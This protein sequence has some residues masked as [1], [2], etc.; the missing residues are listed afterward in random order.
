MALVGG[1]NILLDPRMFM[2]FC[3]AH[4]L[5]RAGR[6]AAFDAGAD[7]FVR[8]EG[9][10]VVLLKRLDDAL[11]DGDRIYAVIKST[12]IN[13]DGGTDSIT[14]PNPAAQKAMLQEAAAKAGIGAD[15]VAY[16]EAHGTGTPLGDPIEAS[17]IGEVFGQARTGG[18]V[19]IGSVKCNIGHLEPA[20]GIAGLIKTALVLNRGQIPPSINFSTP[21]ERIP[22]DALNIEVVG[23]AVALDPDAPAHALVNSFGFGGTNACAL[24]ARHA[25]DVPRRAVVARLVSDAAARAPELT[26]IPLSAP[27]PAHLSAWARDTG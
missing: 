10:G 16:V 4:M 17:A 18:P 20:A 11:R 19:R 1:V 22:F 25:P 12:A 13:Q 2:T 26:P 6:I 15:D 27:T 8:G 5:S 23:R 24:L 7:G 3:R 9:A 21:N 14:A